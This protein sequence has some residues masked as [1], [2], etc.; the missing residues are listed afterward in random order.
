[1]AEPLDW[2]VVKER[3]EAGEDTRSIAIACRRKVADI[4]LTAQLE[5]WNSKRRP[6]IGRAK[7]DGKPKAHANAHAERVSTPCA[8]VEL[9]I[10][11]A[12]L[13]EQLD[14]QTANAQHLHDHE[15]LRQVALQLLQMAANA[16]DARLLTAV[17]NALKTAQDGQRK[18]LGLDKPEPPKQDE[19]QQGVVI[20]PAKEIR[21]QGE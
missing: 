20:L 11:P 19:T 13:A 15:A 2:S 17:S 21:Q 14:A 7:A 9:E 6:T 3:W 18:C 12:D 4:E 10:A 1:M 16:A 8:R 5:R